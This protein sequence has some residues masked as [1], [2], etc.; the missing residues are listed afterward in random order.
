MNS[1]RNLKKLINTELSYVYKSNKEFLVKR[2]KDDYVICSFY[3]LEE[4]DYL[5]NNRNP[6]ISYLKIYDLSEVYAFNMKENI[7]NVIVEIVEIIKEIQ[8]TISK[9]KQI[10]LKYIIELNEN[11]SVVKSFYC[12][13][14]EY[15]KING[16]YSK[17]KY[18]NIKY[19][20]IKEEIEIEEKDKL[21]KKIGKEDINKFIDLFKREYIKEFE[22]VIRENVK[23]ETERLGNL[24]DWRL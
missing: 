5:Y 20:L 13:L 3:S 17:T 18:L 16:K 12:I 24:K 10:H 11:F 9:M 2:K 21:V 14:H 1:Y 23:V 7:R 8:K 19:D 6:Y 15:K 4:R 22:K